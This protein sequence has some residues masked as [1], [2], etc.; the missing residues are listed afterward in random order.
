MSS[1]ID[2]KL[3]SI[4]ESGRERQCT[5]SAATPSSSLDFSSNDYLNLSKHPEIVE[6]ACRATQE[7]GVGSTGSRLISG[8][9]SLLLNLE[10][11]L[12]SFKKKEAALIFNSGFQ[13]NATLLPTLT[14]RSSHIFSDKAIHASLIAGIQ[15]SQCHHHRF[16]HN[17]LSHLEQLLEKTRLDDDKW[18]V[19]ETLFSMH[20]DTIDIEKLIDISKR[21]NAKL[22][23]DEAHAFGL[24]GPTGWGLTEG[25]E[26][27][28]HLI[29]GTFGKAFGSFG[30]FVAIN[31]T[32]ARCLKST[33]PG[34]IF[35]TA[36]PPSVQASI[37]KALDLIPTLDNERQKLFNISKY[38]RTLLLNKDFKLLPSTGPIVPILIGSEAKTLVL[39]SYL[40]EKG[41][42]VK[43]IIPPTVPSKLSLIRLTCHANHQK[44]DINSLVSALE[45]ANSLT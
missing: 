16:K 13:M 45:H 24:Y 41:F 23:L 6:A 38:L 31:N 4:I 1:L 2:K 14:N 35:T 39:S 20:G 10:I 40:K 8:T 33:C 29:A 7:M 42:A 17:D 27:N 30:A 5:I 34:F 28:I 21:Y 9:S 32:I 25:F 19:T 15:A 44:H 26:D 3:H 36:L 12:A 37:D 11:K 22:Y 43:G 18:I